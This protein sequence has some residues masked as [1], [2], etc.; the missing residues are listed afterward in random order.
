MKNLF[1]DE[2]KNLKPYN[3]LAL[4][5]ITI[6]LSTMIGAVVLNLAL[7]LIAGTIPGFYASSNEVSELGARYLTVFNYIASYAMVIINFVAVILIWTKYL[8]QDPELMGLKK[9]DGK[10][11]LIGLALGGFIGLGAIVGY[12][13]NFD[14][15]LQS[16]SLIGMI[17]MILTSLAEGLFVYY[18]VGYSM[19]CLKGVNNMGI[20]LLFPVLIE[21][22]LFGGINVYAILNAV[23]TLVLGLVFYK[24]NDL[25]IPLGIKIGFTFVNGILMGG[26]GNFL[27][28]L[29]MTLVSAGIGLYY[30]FQVKENKFIEGGIR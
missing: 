9:I 16:W 2:H 14:I 25:S 1:F 27:A 30:Y 19:A 11:L 7:V 23:I 22:L 21:V 20:I 8:K 5:I 10:S 28:I 6:L 26:K 18:V 29:I 3:V 17:M 24:T 13:G 15:I 12:L 4:G